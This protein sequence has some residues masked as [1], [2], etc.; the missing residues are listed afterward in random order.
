[1]LFILH[2]EKLIQLFSLHPMDQQVYS[3]CCSF[4]INTQSYNSKNT[5]I[6]TLHAEE[7]AEQF[8]SMYYEQHFQRPPFKEFLKL[9]I[10][11]F[12]VVVFLVFIFVVVVFVV[13]VFIVVVMSSSSSCLQTK[14]RRKGGQLQQWPWGLVQQYTTIV[15]Q[16]STVGRVVSIWYNLSYVPHVF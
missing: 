11:V 1:M 9:Q 10:V 6:G 7:I 16:C 12:V 5:P 3:C 15:Q 8:G 2:R 4:L 14:C 13:V